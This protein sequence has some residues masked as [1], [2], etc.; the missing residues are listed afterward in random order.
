MNIVADINNQ[1]YYSKS[2]LLYACEGRYVEIMKMLIA[3]G[4]NVNAIANAYNGST[5]LIY[6]VQQVSQAV[7]LIYRAI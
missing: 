1:A 4:A 6:C 3:H 5:V 2:P 7:N